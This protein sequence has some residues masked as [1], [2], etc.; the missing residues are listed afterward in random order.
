MTKL[1]GVRCVVLI[2]HGKVLNRNLKNFFRGLVGGTF[3]PQT[4]RYELLYQILAGKLAT[5]VSLHIL[6]ITHCY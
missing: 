5:H 2:R 4:Q 6:L 3:D 1:M